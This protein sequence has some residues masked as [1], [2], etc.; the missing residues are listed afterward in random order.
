MRDTHRLKPS[1][2][3]KVAAIERPDE[4]VEHHIEFLH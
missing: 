1:P 4:V 3:G 2:L